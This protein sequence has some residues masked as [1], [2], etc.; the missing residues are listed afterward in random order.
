MLTSSS[1]FGSQDIKRRFPTV[2]DVGAGPGFI[3]K[4]LDPEITQNLIMTD[5]SSE[6]GLALKNAEQPN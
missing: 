5:S 1:S 2:C 3:S 6:L 4:H